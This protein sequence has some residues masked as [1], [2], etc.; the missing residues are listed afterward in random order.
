MAAFACSGRRCSNAQARSSA[1]KASWAREPRCRQVGRTDVLRGSDVFR[2]NCT[3]G[4]GNILFRKSDVYGIYSEMYIEPAP[5]PPRRL[6]RH[7]M[8]LHLQHLNPPQLKQQVVFFAVQERNSSGNQN[9]QAFKNQ[10]LLGLFSR[11]NQNVLGE[12]VDQ[13]MTLC[14]LIERRRHR[15]TAARSE[16]WI[17]EVKFGINWTTHMALTGH[18]DPNRQ[19]SVDQ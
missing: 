8:L 15:A 1:K 5:C 6:P 14:T 2:P 13:P 16:R 4:S 12:C 9:V 17:W 10:N 3:H 11:K 18:L 7:Q 19:T